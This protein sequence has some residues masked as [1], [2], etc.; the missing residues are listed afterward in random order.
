MDNRH[1]FLDLL[2]LDLKFVGCL[3]SHDCLI[4]LENCLGINC[5]N[6]A[7]N[8]VK[9]FDF[10][11]YDNFKLLYVWYNNNI[12]SGSIFD[13][14]DSIIDSIL[15]YFNEVDID[16]DLVNSLKSLDYVFK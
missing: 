5:S 9:V 8:N 14:I 7:P 10:D 12:K 1:Y 16:I 6:Y 15:N 3:N 4:K 13:D 2:D 11:N